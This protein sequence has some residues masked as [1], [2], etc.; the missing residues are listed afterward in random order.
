MSFLISPGPVEIEF[1]TLPSNNI[2]SDNVDQKLVI[3]FRL[4][5]SPEPQLTLWKQT[6]SSS[7]RSVDGYSIINDPRIIISMTNV[8]FV[9]LAFSDEGSYMILSNNTEGEFSIPFT[10]DVTGILIVIIILLYL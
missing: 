4:F 9:S 8:T 2:A 3:P 10:V 7:K 6:S 5:G 1:V